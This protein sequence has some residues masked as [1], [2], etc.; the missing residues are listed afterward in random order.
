[1]SDSRRGLTSL[2]MPDLRSLLRAVEERRV[3]VPV[4]ETGLSALGVSAMEEV[5]AV[6]AGLPEPGVRAVLETAIA[7]RVHRAAPQ[8]DLVWTGPEARDATARDTAVVVRQLF[9]QARKSVLVGGFSFDH[10]ADIFRPLH[11]V[12]VA[13]AVTAT[14]FL[15][16]EGHADS[17][18]GGDAYAV[19]QIDRFFADNWPFVPPRPDVY[20]DPRTAV[21][22][23]PWASLHAKCVVIDDRRTLITSA[24]FTDRGQTRN[25]ETGVLIDDDTFARGLVRQWRGLIASG[26]VRKFAG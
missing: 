8:L 25:I 6:L 1:M 15:D 20:Y 21:P 26:L 22:G 11:A 24:N 7:E 4:T 23:P 19:A 17:A 12:M 3:A 16:I 5:A 14:F 2:S 9:E 13:H 18:A 10:G